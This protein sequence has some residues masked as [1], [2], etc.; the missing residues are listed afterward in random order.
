MEFVVS[1]LLI[2]FLASLA[3]GLTGFGFALVLVPLLSL[4]YDPRAAVVVSITLGLATKIPLLYWD[5]RHVQ[6]RLLAPLVAGALAGIVGGARLVVLTDPN[7]LRLGIAL[8]VLVFATIMLFNVRVQIKTTNLAVGLVGLLSGVLTG[9]TSM[10]GPP[11]VLF[12]VNQMWAKRSLR[13]NLVAFFSAS[14]L[15]TMANFA[16]MGVVTED[17]LRLDL[18]MLPGVVVGLLVGNAIYGR[19]EQV[20]LYR[21]VILFVIGTGVLGLVS[22]LQ[23]LSR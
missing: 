16:A 11:V 15:F 14:S 9:S 13:A 6:W 18:V 1:V 2:G 17:V 23:A 10:G 20:V 22:S 3:Q 21:A 5:Y 19:M 8:T 4:I 12:G 7:L